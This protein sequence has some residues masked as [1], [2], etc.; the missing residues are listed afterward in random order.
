MTAQGNW[1]APLLEQ[2]AAEGEEDVVTFDKTTEGWEDNVS[3]HSSNSTTHTPTSITDN[4]PLSD[5]TAQIPIAATAITITSRRL[6]PVRKKKPLK[7]NKSQ[8]KISYAGKT[9]SDQEIA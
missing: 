3:V 2:L 7:A 6:Q 1:Y 9:L 5:P 4:Q 8:A